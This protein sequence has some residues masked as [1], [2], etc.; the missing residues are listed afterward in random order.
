V[1]AILKLQIPSHNSGNIM[2]IGD[3]AA[4]PSGPLTLAHE[5]LHQGEGREGSTKE[6]RELEAEAVAFVVAE[7]IGIQ[8]GKG[9]SDYIQLYKGDLE[10]LAA[11][12][13]AVRK[14]ASTILRGLQECSDV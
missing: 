2:C 6:Q 8:M 13:S 14:A 11:P 10:K 12:L 7:S 4:V 1:L 9:S 5:I 3:G